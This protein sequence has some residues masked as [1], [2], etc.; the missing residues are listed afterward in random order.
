MSLA[1]TVS[2]QDP[3]QRSTEFVPVE[4]GGETTS[5]EALVVAAYL[6]MWLLLAFFIWTGWRKQRALDVRIGELER[7]LSA[8]R[9]G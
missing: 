8:A 2:T 5:A 7:G 1:Q 3:S 6:V 4:G 9:K